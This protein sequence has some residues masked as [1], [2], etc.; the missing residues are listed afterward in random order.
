MVVPTASTEQCASVNP[1]L[2]YYTRDHALFIETVR[3]FIT[4]EIAPYHAQWGEDGVVPRELF[5]ARAR[6]AFFASACRRLSGG[7]GVDWLYSAIVPWRKWGSPAPV[8]WS[9]RST[10]K[11]SD[12][13]IS[14]IAR[15]ASEVMKQIIA[16][17]LY[18]N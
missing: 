8:G 11:W 14:R 18:G 6:L 16:R 17:E 15:G 1:C 7:S 3:R 4:H 10:P 5:C 9:S 12:A 13:G 2:E